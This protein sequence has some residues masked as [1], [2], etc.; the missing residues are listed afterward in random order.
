MLRTE[1]PVSTS[2]K[3]LLKMIFLGTFYEIFFVFF[4]YIR[5]YERLSTASFSKRGPYKTKR[6]LRS[7][8]PPL[9]LGY[10]NPAVQSFIRKLRISDHVLFSGIV[11]LSIKKLCVDI[12]VKM[13]QFERSYSQ[14]IARV[15]LRDL[16]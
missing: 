15:T 1:L 5:R 11:L 8:V 2:T 10:R 6:V 16:K 4:L 9:G 7:A 13:I 3:Y 14:K 12:H